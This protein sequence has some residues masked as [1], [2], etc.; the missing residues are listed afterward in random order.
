MKNLNFSKGDGLIPAIV[1]DYQTKK[2]LMLGYMNQESFEKTNETGLVTFYSRSRQTLWTKG[3][4]SGNYLQVKEI[5][6]DCDQDTLLV[7]AQP[8]GPVCHKGTDTC[9]NETNESSVV[10]LEYLQDLINERKARMPEGSYTTSLFE[11]GI[12]RIAQ[13][14]GEEAVETVIEAM[15]ND[16]EAFL[17]EGADLLYHMLVLFTEKGTS[18]GEIVKV[19]EDRHN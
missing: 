16:D 11:K 6:L 2:V 17:N 5:L 14:V 12:G 13:K 1:Q 3:E 18:I 4:T 10:F 8:K 19:L 15:G 9:F 7:M